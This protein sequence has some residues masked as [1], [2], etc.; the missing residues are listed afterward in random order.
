ML[1]HD[2]I[3]HHARPHSQIGASHGRLEIPHCSR[4]APR[5]AG[6]RLIR[7][8]TRL[9]R[10][11]EIGIIWHP[12][13]LAGLNKGA[14]Q[15][16][17]IH[18][19][20]PERPARTMPVTR[21]RIIILG[22]QKIRFHILE[23]PAMAAEFASPRVI[24][25]GTTTREHFGIDRGATSEHACLRIG[26]LAVQGMLLRGGFQPPSQR[27]SGHFIKA[28]GKMDIGICILRASLKQQDTHI[29]R[30]GQAGSQCASRR[31][32]ADNDEILHHTPPT[33]MNTRTG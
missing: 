20:N 16:M 23:R 21:K 24:I 10:A 15:R 26:N 7:A 5:L 2:T 19:R 1:D 13:L 11:V 25:L 3:D 28:D 14:G 4:A 33:L 30:L 31:A 22:L 29:G 18:R 6:G 8:C 9:M 12:D 17:G 27:P 32:C